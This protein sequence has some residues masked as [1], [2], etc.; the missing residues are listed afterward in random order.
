MTPELDTAA[1][2]KVRT[3][4]ESVLSYFLSIE[5]LLEL[6]LIVLLALIA[7]LLS[8]APRAYLRT[9]QHN[10]SGYPLLNHAAGILAVVAFPLTWLI[11]QWLADALSKNL[12]WRE[13]IMHITAS[14]LSAWVVIRVA[15]TFIKNRALANAISLLAWTVAALNIIGWLG[16]TESFL[17]GVAITFGEAR[18]SLLSIF[19]G[20]VSL[21]VLLWASNIL[22]EFL[23]SRIH[24]N[25]S[26]TPS[27]QVLF[28]KLLKVV[29]LVVALLIAVSAVGIDL[30]AFAVVGGA[31]GVGVGFGLQKIVSNL[32]SGVILLLDNSIKPGD[33]IAVGD[34]YGRVDSLGARYV[35]VTTLDG[36]E[37]LIPNEDL[38]VNRVENWSHSNDLIR[39]R[40]GVGVHYQSDVKKA[41]QLCLDAAKEVERVLEDP[42]PAVLMHG[43]GDNSVDLEIRYWINDPMNGRANVASQ[44]LVR[45]WDKFKEHG[46][47]IPYPQRDLHLRTPTFEALGELIR[48]K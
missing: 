21:V 44:I 34:Y 25:A 14:L 22:S 27:A 32:V 33:I 28:S 40:L 47:E 29:L 5:T 16:W 31:V 23:E 30:T 26:L 39:L 45:V 12:G 11:L 36:I 6:G 15:S 9:V 13:G 20:V 48:P 18:I 10:E 8:R 19:K 24:K 1:L 17:D 42:P 7:V 43:F 3:F 2:E 37:Y 38:I 4:A 46:V 35:S 41:M